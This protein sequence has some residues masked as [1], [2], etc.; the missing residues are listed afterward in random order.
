MGN[1]NRSKKRRSL[2]GR[3]LPACF[4]AAGL[5]TL[6]GCGAGAGMA[7]PQ[8]QAVPGGGEADSTG[9]EPPESG[10]GGAR[11]TITLATLFGSYDQELLRVIRD[12]NSQSLQYQV[13]LKDYMGDAAGDIQASEVEQAQNRVLMELASGKGPDLLSMDQFSKE[14]L[15][16]AGMLANLYSLRSRAE[17]CEEMDDNLLSSIQ[18][19][20]K[21][22][23]IGP[24]FRIHTV[25][26]GKAIGGGNGWTM[27]ELLDAFEKQGKGPEALVGFY[28][29]QSVI[30]TL[31][32]FELDSYIDWEDETAD[33][34][35][36]GFY[37]LLE[38]A[39]DYQDRQPGHVR[40]TTALHSGEG[41]ASLENIFQV[42]QYQY[43]NLLYDGCMVIKGF[44]T[45]EGTGVGMSLDR[46]LGICATG[47]LQGAWDFLQFYLREYGREDGVGFP[48]DRE[49]REEEFAQ[50]MNQE[51]GADGQRIPK[52]VYEEED[53][54]VYIYAASPEEISALRE[55]VG[56]VD[57]EGVGNEAILDI[58][59]EEAYAY[60]SGSLSA[61][62]AAHNCNN[63][64][65]LY[66]SE[67]GGNAG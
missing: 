16:S 41:L 27:E 26:A 33:F 18:T 61:E 23:A 11:E 15:G 9:T 21:L 51:Y 30:E 62:T 35:Q 46:S 65:N 2:W 49:R 37:R 36:E 54:A 59:T 1:R 58:I 40:R 5:L 13:E 63:R 44:P 29:D 8:A 12:Y 43:S 32:M 14:A 47:N 38:F 6:T 22:Y 56:M 64:V 20:E 7:G 4:W 31:A 52:A 55:L 67:L 53:G 60:I 57:R 3:I 66:L 10:S 28:A 34:A 17:W 39:K 19:G 48:M 45:P 50:A 24:R 25:A 42:Q